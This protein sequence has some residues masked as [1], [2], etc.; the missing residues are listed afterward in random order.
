MDGLDSGCGGAAEFQP[1]ALRAERFRPFL[2]DELAFWRQ[3][4]AG[5]AR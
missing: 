4:V 5:S 2:A 1:F 3:F